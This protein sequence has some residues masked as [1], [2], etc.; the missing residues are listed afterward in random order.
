MS[1]SIP[2]DA[3]L[4]AAAFLV[5]WPLGRGQPDAARVA[6]LVAQVWGADTAAADTLGLRN[7]RCLALHQALCGGRIEAQVTCPD[8]AAAN[9]AE[10]PVEDLLALPAPPAAVTVETESGPTRFGLPRMAELAALAGGGAEAAG[11][12]AARLA[13]DGPNGPLSPGAIASAAAAWEAADPAG[14]IALGVTCVGCGRAMT[15][16]VDPPVFVA[17]DFDRLADR[18]MGEVDTIARAY[19][20][21]EAEILAL[22][23][24]RRQR[25]LAL[26]ATGGPSGRLT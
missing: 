4:G 13:L 10:L 8:C 16:T 26:A 25:Y 2:S 22:P 3:A 12:L 15:A 21:T 20:W 1:V 9:E 17:R 6:A 7:Q 5:A 11:A 18:L 23:R 24:E 14:A 19:G